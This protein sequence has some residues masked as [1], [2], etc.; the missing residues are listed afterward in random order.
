MPSMSQAL[1]ELLGPPLLAALDNRLGEA[2]V[3]LSA[4]DSELPSLLLAALLG[5]LDDHL[6]GEEIPR[7][8]L[9]EI[10]RSGPAPE[11]WLQGISVCGFR[12]I[13]EEQR[14]EL[15][16]TAG[17]TVVLGRN[18]SGKSSFAEAAELLL[19]GDNLRWAGRHAAWKE[20]WRNLHHNGGRHVALEV[21]VDGEAGVKSL[22][23]SWKVGAEKLEDCL[24]DRENGEAE[25]APDWTEASA[26]FRPFLSY[27]EL[28]SLIEAGPSKLHDALAA[29][30]GLDGLQTI[31][32]DL[33]NRRLETQKPGKIAAG[34][35]KEVRETCLE[36][37]K[38]QGEAEGGDSTVADERFEAAA[39]LL[40]G[41]NWKLDELHRLAD[42]P[43]QTSDAEQGS[44]Q[45]VETLAETPEV[46][47]AA[48]RQTVEDLAKALSR[49]G[50]LQSGSTGRAAQL[51]EVLRTATQHYDSHV[52]DEPRSGRDLPCPV[53]NATP[54]DAAWREAASDQMEHLEC[55]VAVLE[56]A[57]AAARELVGVLPSPLPD[58]VLGSAVA[59][60]GSSP[61]IVEALDR[62]RVWSARLGSL[63]SEAAELQDKV[64]AATSLAKDADADVEALDVAILAAA[65][66]REQ[67]EQAWL[68]VRDALREW[69]PTARKEMEF[70]PLITRLKSAEDWLR[71]QATLLY[72]ERFAPLEQAVLQNWQELRA[73]SSVSIEEIRFEG[74]STKRTVN[75]G[76]TVDGLESPALSVMSQGELHALALA[77]FLPRATLDESPFRFVVI[78]DPVQAMDPAR[79]DGLARVLER[80]AET[81]QVVVF[82][83]DD[84]LAEA[85][86]RLEI[87]ARILE[88]QRGES[89]SVKVVERQDEVSRAISEAMALAMTDD[90]PASARDRV[91]P[92][93]CRIA[94]E[95]AAVEAFRRRRL[96][97]GERHL[98]VQE[99]IRLHDKLIPKVAL[100]VFDDASK[101][102]EV[103]SHLNKKD[104][105]DADMLQACNRG[106][107]KGLQGAASVD[108][109]R[110]AEKLS[111]F[112]RSQK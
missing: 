109:V 16:P 57:R 112:L 5:S 53:C 66:Y 89:S 81:R 39:K 71:E 13:G 50:E 15:D 37:A 42:G 17:L 75:L 58:E 83:H 87:K 106:S 34:K 9:P 76:V 47:L 48:Y 84:R 1:P 51:L 2:E 46:A 25:Q 97:R 35:A 11:A 18:G 108:F 30:L 70:R 28:G 69:L 49:E 105:R 72:N 96:Q 62:V 77:L 20:G 40:R 59:D 55:E 88:V 67:R 79:V 8:E 74:K 22:R 7:P 100:A 31:A 90:L 10:S 68:P 44:G 33:K 82:T 38:E 36:R 73:S 80:T 23:R 86:H 27:N 56:E 110:R 85:I 41:R 26:T 93:L 45:A 102:D 111:G 99:E 6:A 54:L 92:G 64:A 63:H 95:E 98:D 14:L 12:G 65:S 29:I 101:A 24:L 19:T 3:E 94:L 103:L 43:A 107:H 91:V 61:E 21:R 52:G 78:D 60:L 32:D 104:R 4:K